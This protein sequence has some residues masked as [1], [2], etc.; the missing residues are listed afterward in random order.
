MESEILETMDVND[1]NSKMEEA[2]HHEVA[3][4]VADITDKEE[5]N[6]Y[7]T[8]KAK[9]IQGTGKH[10]IN[11]VIYKENPAGISRL[12]TKE[13]TS[14]YD[15]SD[16]SEYDTL[17]LVPYSETDSSSDEMPTKTKTR[18]KRFKVEKAMWFS[19]KN[20]NRREKGK[21]YFGRTKV[22]GKWSYD[23]EREPREIKERCQCRVKN[24][25]LKCS[26]ITE[27]QRKYIFEYFWSLSWREKKVFV[28]STVKSEFIKRARDR[29][30]PEQSRRNQAFKYYLKTGD[31]ENKSL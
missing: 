27:Q 3:D 7:R 1:T 8:E 5:T 11:K 18:R 16:D 15:I 10:E 25:T 20:R 17:N 26:Q 14:A 12:E 6:N 22:N 29:K 4:I 28:D 2:G 19:E 21:R 13:I 23:I 31:Q 24:G 9:G 30:V